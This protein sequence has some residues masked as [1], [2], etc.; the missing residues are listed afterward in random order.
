[1]LMTSQQIEKWGNYFRYFYF[2]EVMSFDKFMELVKAGKPPQ[3]LTVDW[4]KVEGAYEGDVSNE[5]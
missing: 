5:F 4:N 3:R 2:Q 1:M